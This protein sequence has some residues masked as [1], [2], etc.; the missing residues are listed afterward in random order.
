MNNSVTMPRRVSRSSEFVNGAKA[1]IPLIIGAIPFGILFGTL[2]EPSGLSVLGALA[3]SLIVFA[4]ASQF[5][6]LG[7]LAAGAAVPV[8]IATTFV[9]NLRHL[10]YAANLVPKVRHLPQHWRALMAFGLTDETFAAVSNRYLQQE[11]IRDAHWFY[12]G[13]FLAMYSNWVLCTALGVALGELF[14]D[15]TQWGLDF[16]MSVTFIGMVIPYL[17]SKP[18]WAAVIVA[19][20]MAIATAAIPHKLGLMI[21]AI[22]GIAVGLSLHMMQSKK[23]STQGKTHE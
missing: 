19:G 14:P 16:A 12:L 8:I 11:D 20:A 9:V 4:G 1:T 10:L 18:M 17:K 7:L 6:A 21:A 13:S 2:A 15:M 3:M 23:H 5:I 22:S